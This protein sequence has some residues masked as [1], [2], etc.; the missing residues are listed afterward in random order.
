VARPAAFR[1]VLAVLA[2]LAAALFA[3]G[4]VSVPTGGP[5][6]SYPITQ[7]TSSQNQPYLQIVPSHPGTNWSPKQIVTGFLTASASF[8]DSGQVAKEYLTPQE[9]KAWNPSWS[10][11]VYRNGPNVRGPVYTPAKNAKNPKDKA[12]E[13]ATV[14]ITGSIQANLSGYGSY[15]VPSSSASNAPDNAQPTFKLVQVGGQWRI[16]EAPSELLLTSDSFSYDYQL[17]NLYFFD[18]TNNYLVPDPV[19][20]PLQATSSDLGGLVHDL[21]S[22]PRDWLSEGATKTAFPPKTRIGSVT[23]DGVTAVIDLEGTAIA[24]A[25][26]QMMQQ[27][28]AQLLLTLKSG[29]GQSGQAVQLIQV[30]VNGKQWPSASQLQGHSAESP[31]DGTSSKFY[32]VDAAGYLVSREGTAGKPVRVARMGTGYSQIAVSPDGR[33]LAALRGGILY[34]GLLGGPLVKRNG[35]GYLSMSWD[36]SDNLWATTYDQIVM[37][38]AG[39]SPNSAEGQPIVATVESSNG[40]TEFGPFGALRVAPDGVRIAVIV[41]H[42]Q[43]NFGAISEQAGARPDRQSVK[44]VFSPVQ[45]SLAGGAFTALTWYGHNDVITLANPG[46]TVTEYPASGGAA[47]SISTSSGLQAI[48]ASLGQPLLGSLAKRHLVSD[49]SLTGSWMFLSN[50]SSPTYPG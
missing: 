11:I 9:A 40:I 26:S 20:V 24:K 6:Q 21:I 46:P 50:G 36:P 22:P 16:E 19:Y 14:V 44:I 31:P 27:V 7:G 3:A 48:S 13:T 4:C 28:S 35:A 34:T 33:Y 47:T 38:K 45:E 18:P 15:A 30:E 39:A 42:S 17:R 25:N 29:S 49:A 8:A 32:Y 41:N 43:L 2:A 5:V 12:G 37:I 1:P 23:L 10:A